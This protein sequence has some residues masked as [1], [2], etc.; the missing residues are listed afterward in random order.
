[1]PKLANYQNEI[2]LTEAQSLNKAKKKVIEKMKGSLIDTSSHVDDKNVEE[3]ILR[4]NKLLEEQINILDNMD[5]LI[6]PSGNIQG[7]PSLPKLNLSNIL[8]DTTT[9]TEIDPELQK[10]LHKQPFTYVPFEPEPSEYIPYSEPDRTQSLLNILQNGQPIQD[11]LRTQED[12]LLPMEGEVE[13]LLPRGDELAEVPPSEP[14]LKKRKGKT[15]QLEINP[16]QPIRNDKI[17][18][19]G[20]K[21]GRKTNVQKQEERAR[22]EIRKNKEKEDK[23]NEYLVELKNLVDEGNEEELNNLLNQ[24][25]EE[26]PDRQDDIY[27]F[28]VQNDL[29]IDEGDDITEYYTG[30]QYPKQSEGKFN[31]YIYPPEEEFFRLKDSN[32]K[33]AYNEEFYPDE[34]KGEGRFKLKVRIHK[35][36]GGARGTRFVKEG[37]YIDYL[38]YLNKLI[39]NQKQINNTLN[40][41]IQYIKYVPIDVIN[42]FKQL[43]SEYTDK[44]NNIYSE[45]IREVRNRN[46]DIIRQDMLIHMAGMTNI[47]LNV[48]KNKWNEFINIS[49]LYLNYF[50]D[51][52]KN[53]NEER[54]RKQKPN[55]LTLNK[56]G[57]GQYYIG[58]D[59]PTRYL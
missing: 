36:K 3:G 23:F 10:V 40:R 45:A 18:R 31:Y 4:V 20:K 12:E 11:T 21:R 47:N 56:K 51:A 8:E 9:K 7:R 48:I 49:M 38:T 22:E 54:T 46:G 6:N 13:P 53:Y 41:N 2:D 58:N 17:I 42:N 39:S 24:V 14:I 15:S 43:S 57:M 29:I 34:Y 44:V 30:P 52:L 19:E 26:Y 28:I 25:L 37:A 59:I 1:M 16:Y 50:K 33:P 32:K 27:K 5:I 35:K 55:T